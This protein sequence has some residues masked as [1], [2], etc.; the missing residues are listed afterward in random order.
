[1]KTHGMSDEPGGSTVSCTCGWVKW[2]P[3]SK[4]RHDAAERHR[5]QSGHDWLPQAVTR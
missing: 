2:H 1:M 5:K 4:V 3:T